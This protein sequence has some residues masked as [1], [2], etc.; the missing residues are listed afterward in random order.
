MSDLEAELFP[1]GMSLLGRQIVWELV[2]AHWQDE[3]LSVKALTLAVGGSENGTRRHLQRLEQAGLLLIR[4]GRR[5]RRSLEL[6]PS[7][8]LLEAIDRLLDAL[9]SAIQGSKYRQEV[10]SS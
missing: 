10:G 3:R 9:E 7:P 5:D 8:R 2:R 1:V 6:S 4:K